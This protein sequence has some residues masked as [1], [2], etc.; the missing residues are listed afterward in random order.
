M[1]VC[2]YLSLHCCVSEPVIQV[3]LPMQRDPPVSVLISLYGRRSWYK[4]C[5]CLSVCWPVCDLCVA[6]S[7]Y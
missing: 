7:M 3:P 6:L 4:S 2:V 5:I 1:C